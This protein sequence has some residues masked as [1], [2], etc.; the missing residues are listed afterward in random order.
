MR[1]FR[2]QS[3]W[4]N[5]ILFPFELFFH[6]KVIIVEE[7]QG[8]DFRNQVLIQNCKWIMISCSPSKKKQY[9]SVYIIQKFQSRFVQTISIFEIVAKTWNLTFLTGNRKE[10]KL[11]F[12]QMLNP[13]CWMTS[14]SSSSGAIHPR[15]TVIQNG[16]IAYF[17]LLHDSLIFADFLCFMP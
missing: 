1:I 2:N 17:Y 14:V 8:I 6:L 12:L 3:T 10:R 4:L 11:T 15:I 7:S 9:K 16:Q 5:Q 13:E